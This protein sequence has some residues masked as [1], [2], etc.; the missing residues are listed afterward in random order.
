MSSNPTS[1]Q[2][3]AY[4]PASDKWGDFEQWIYDILYRVN[5]TNGEN[6]VYWE[7]GNEPDTSPSWYPTSPAGGTTRYTNYFELYKHVVNAVNKYE[8]DNP[9]A[10]RVKIGGPAVTVHSFNKMSWDPYNWV[11]KFLQDAAAS[12]IRVD[13]VSMHMYGNSTGYQGLTQK[14]DIYPSVEEMLDSVY[15]YRLSYDTA[16]SYPIPQFCIT[17]WGPTENV[18]DYYGE[19]NGSAA[20][21]AFDVGFLYNIMKKNT[22]D[23]MLWLSMKDWPDFSYF[24]TGTIV[25]EPIPGSITKWMSP[26]MFTKDMVTKAS[27]N[28]FKMISMLPSTRISVSKNV[29]DS[30]VTA[31]ASKNGAGESNEIAVMMWNGYWNYNQDKSNT[32]SHNGTIVVNNFPTTS[33]KYVMYRIDESN[34]NANYYSKNNL[35]YNT[36]NS[37]LK[38]V[39]SGT[40][41]VTSNT[42]QLPNVQLPKE[43]VVLCMLYPTSDTTAPTAPTISTSNATTSAVKYMIN[44]TAEANCRI[45]IQ[46][47][48]IDVTVA[49]C[50]ADSSGNWYTEVPLTVGS[51]V[52][53]AKAIDKQ[54]N[55]SSYSTTKTITK[56]TVSLA[57]PTITSLET[58]ATTSYTL[59]G[60][61]TENSY[62]NIY[63][64][65][66][67]TYP[68][69]NRSLLKNSC[70][71]PVGGSYSIAITLEA[72]VHNYI[73]VQSF[74]SKSD[75]NLSAESL[76]KD[77]NCTAEANLI[78][79]GSFSSDFTNWGIGA[80][81][82]VFST[83][84]SNYNSASKCLSVQPN[85]TS[86]CYINTP[87][88]ASGIS[89]DDSSTYEL[90]FWYKTS[91]TRSSGSVY[92][93]IL[94]RDANHTPIGYETYG[95]TLSSRLLEIN[96]SQ[97]SYAKK[98]L[99]ITLPSSD[100]GRH[101]G[102]KSV[103]IYIKND[104]NSGF[105][106]WIDDMKLV[107]N[108]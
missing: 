28:A 1:P 12:T 22:V 80:A 95:S 91:G 47:N 42:V 108:Q 94:D 82:T 62:I 66:N 35:P 48:T 101:I 79:N 71:V 89:L 49:S 30:E 4:C 57:T 3:Y 106:V 11:Q 24:P 73:A 32:I 81:S 54:N 36:A 50:Y 10:P 14:S 41:T 16:C 68:K 61:A 8:D 23:K 39:G 38:I 45:E 78:S 29:L 100:S 107:K 43:S 46:D 44:G 19:P 64:Y 15:A 17:E 65:K 26:A 103:T 18:S 52:I 5:V 98:T 58:S 104:A 97:A 21:A 25:Y 9:T 70:L 75:G 56:N 27:Y 84:G 53:K 93:Q 83:S 59:T 33:C 2:F 55:I 63:S 105:N 51:N 40:L 60:T 37:N 67:N 69:L 102:T 72:G 87:N 90:S 13:F 96:S 7:V 88:D 34:S 20:G 92:F 31:I 85:G 6:V 77:I 86:T 99:T 76:L 74:D